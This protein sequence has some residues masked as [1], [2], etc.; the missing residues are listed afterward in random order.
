LLLQ[1]HMLQHLLLMMAAPPLLWL[2]APLFPLLRGLPRPVRTYWV[3]PLVRAPSLRRS[4]ERLTHPIAAFALFAAATWF[5]HLPA[6]YEL[7][8]RSPGWHYLQ[9]ACFLGTALLFWS[10]VVRPYPSRPGWSPWL[11]LP[12]LI[13]ADLQNTVLSA[14]LTFSDRPWYPHYTE[15]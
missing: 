14:L 7:A 1:V 15:V 8:L 3:A 12:C 2:G 11:L 5:W 13:L 6:A 4:F 10:P 9:H